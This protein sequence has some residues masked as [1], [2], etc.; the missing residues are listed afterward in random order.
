MSG[1]RE[2]KRL[3]EIMETAKAVVSQLD[4]DKVLAIILKKAMEITKTRAGSIA[5]FTAKTGT[6]RI[7][8][9]KG[10]SRGFIRNCEWKIRRGGLTDRI[11]KSQ[12]VTVIDNS[13]NKTFFTNPVAVSEGIKS[14]VCVPLLYSEDVVGS[15]RR[16]L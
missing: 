1:T 6:M 15:L 5:L 16:R 9:Q 10:F 13:T 12:A 2:Q 8:A 14:L 3:I 4:L 7:H 11:L